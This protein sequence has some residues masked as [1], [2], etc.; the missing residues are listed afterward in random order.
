[1]KALKDW[2]SGLSGRAPTF[3]C[4]THTSNSSITKKKK[5]KGKSITVLKVM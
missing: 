2:W 3:K 4:E 1:M 5:K